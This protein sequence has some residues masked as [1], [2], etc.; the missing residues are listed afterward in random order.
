MTSVQ[1]PDGGKAWFVHGRRRR[2]CHLRPV[3]IEGHVLTV[4]FTFW[5]TG[6]A[7]FIA[8]RN[9]GLPELLAAIT[10]ILAS[11]LLYVVTALRMSAP[12]AN[13]DKGR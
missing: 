6:I 4:G 5:V 12:A 11:T 1:M 7:W 10:M 8:D 9:P 2:G 3:S 13:R